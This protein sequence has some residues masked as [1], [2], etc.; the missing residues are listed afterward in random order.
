MDGTVALG[1]ARWCLEIR[2]RKKYAEQQVGPGEDEVRG[3]HSPLQDQEDH[4]GAVT[5]FFKHR[6]NHQRSIAHRV[7]REQEENDLP[8][9]RRSHESVEES[10]VRDRWRISPADQI[11]QEVERGDDQ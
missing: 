2:G 5:E 3:V 8:G 7:A 6:R 4:S 1:G 9:Q 10:R 11:K